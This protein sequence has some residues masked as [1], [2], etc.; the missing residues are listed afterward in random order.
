M[1][2]S[3][4]QPGGHGQPPAALWSWTCGPTISRSRPDRCTGSVASS[5]RAAGP[6]P[7]GPRLRGRGRPGARRRPMRWN[8]SSGS[9]R[10]R[11]ADPVWSGPSSRPSAPPPSTGR[12]RSIA[13]R[14][15]ARWSPSTCPSSIRS[16][17]TTDGGD[18][19]SP[20]GA[21]S[22][23]PVRCTSAH[24]QPKLPTD[25]GFGQTCAWKQTLQLQA[26]MARRRHHRVHV[27][28][29]LVR[30]ARAARKDRSDRD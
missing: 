7:D 6:Q 18:A 15:R 28:P 11:P 22:R 14:P 21:T 2:S 30:Q 1:P 26:A 17:R 12:V 9:S 29:L 24:H 3:G 20:S 4:G 10:V 27:P 8:G 23:L 16:N 5:S 25:T 13:L 19:A